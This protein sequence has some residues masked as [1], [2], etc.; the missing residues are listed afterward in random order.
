MKKEI[1]FFFVFLFVTTQ[2][3]FSQ[4]Y[5]GQLP[6]DFSRK[7]KEINCGPVPDFYDRTGMIEPPFFYGFHPGPKENSAIFWC[8]SEKEESYFLVSIVKNKIDSFFAWHNYPGGLSLADSKTW[9]LSEFSYV[10]NPDKKGPKGEFTKFTPIK[11]EYDGLIT[12]F[13]KHEDEWL[14]LLFD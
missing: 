11:D 9:E 8:F 14:Y 13:Y 5:S 10:K 6:K 3:N 4:N 7:G 12:L 2:D 1:F